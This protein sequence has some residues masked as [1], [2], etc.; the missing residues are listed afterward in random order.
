MPMGQWNA[1]D[2]YLEA[3]FL[4]ED[5]ILSE[6]L[7]VSD[8]EGLDPIAVSATQGQFLNLLVQMKGA[9]RVLELGTL[10]G[11]STICMA[12]ALPGDGALVTLELAH[13]HAEVARR[14]I[15]GAGVGEKVDI[16]VG[17]ALDTLRAMVAAD[18][19]P[20]DFV[21][22][23]ADKEGYPE[24][25]EQVMKLVRKG[26]VIIADNV[27]RDGAVIDE[28]TTD[29]SVMGIRRFNELVASDSRV[30]STALQTVG[31][32]GYDGFAMIVVTAD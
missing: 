10:G 30:T 24:Y 1:V 2:K 9:R 13:H 11:Y 25:L 17:P 22:M 32:K 26:A 14:N 19:A 4:S 7:R 20:F 8:I 21:F 28:S 6:T 3:Q 31:S 5:P 23:D 27:V 15:D 12:R 16:R 18:E 29:T